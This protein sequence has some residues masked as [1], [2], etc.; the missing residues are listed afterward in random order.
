MVEPGTGK[1]K[2]IAASKDF[3]SGSDQTTIN[4]A[5]DAAHGGGIGVS[6]GSTFKVFTLMA[7]LD[8][9]IPV[10]TKIPSPAHISLGGFKPC[11]Y[12]GV[13]AG[14]RYSDTWLGGGRWSPSNAGDSEK[15][16][17]DLKKG[18]WE[19][20]NTFYAQLEKRV[21]V[22]DAIKMAQNFGMKRADG[23]P[24][25]PVPSQV[26]GTNEIDM[27][28]LAAAYAGIAAR[29]KYCAPIAITE[30][31][32]PT[33]KKLALPRQDCHQ[34]VD[35]SLADETTSILRG[36]LTKGTAK[37]VPSV[38]RPAAGKTGTCEEFSC[39]V[40][41]GYTPNLAA[42]VAY[43][44]LRGPFD[45]KVYGIYGATIPGPIWARSMRYALAGQPVLSFTD[46]TSTYGDV[47]T[48]TVPDVKGESVGVAKS[49]LAA[50]G[51]TTTVSATSVPSRQ[52]KGTV[53]YTSPS[54]DST[55]DQGST[56]LIFISDGS[57]ARSASPRPSN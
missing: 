42:A 55:A 3:G 22:C 56:V 5:A 16:T 27:V 37:K 44:D 30:V 2:A 41:A 7:A 29:G 14:H 47:G 35:Q 13:Y 12:T 20:V 45:H 57:G 53:A 6:A 18:T 4:I 36:V 34:A 39:A 1:I 46:P 43:W 10:D 51:F 54:G 31:T 48:I 23:N 19:S 26:L 38:G 9:G 28:H 17:F 40:F 24:L 8:Q 50:A 33:G 49:E 25:V 32:D 52:P 21:G 11:R 15:G